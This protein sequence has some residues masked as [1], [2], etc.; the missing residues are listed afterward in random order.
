MDMVGENGDIESAFGPVCEY[1]HG[2]SAS[3]AIGG[4]WICGCEY[5][6]YHIGCLSSVDTI[7]LWEGVEEVGQDVVGYGEDV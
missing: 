5:G 6:G 4:D 1:D 2:R 3:G 7:S